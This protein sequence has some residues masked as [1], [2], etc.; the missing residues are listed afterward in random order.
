[1]EE[2]KSAIPPSLKRLIS[3]STLSTIP[4]SCSSLLQFFL[5]LPQF[6]QIVGDLVDRDRA[7]CG[8]NKDAALESKHNGNDC[9]AKADYA[10]ALRFYS[11]ALRDAPSDVDVMGRNLVSTLY[12]N[13]ATV[14]HRVGLLVECLRDCGRALVISPHYTKAWYRRGKVNASLGNYE[15]AVRDLTVAMNVESAL[16][17]KRKIES[18]LKQY[19]DRK[20]E[21]NGLLD[22][23]SEKNF[24]SAAEATHTKLEC[25]STPTKGRGMVSVADI[26]PSSLL[27]IEEPFAAVI[28]KH[29]RDTHCHFC[30]NKLPVDTVPC[31]SCT[32]PLYCSHQCQAQA[33]GQKAGSALKSRHNHISLSDDLEKYIADITS[34]GF[35]TEQNSE[36]SHECGGV[37]WPVVLPSEIILAGRILMKL[38]KQTRHSG[39]S[40]CVVKNMDLCHNYG[41]HPSDV[42]LYLHIHSIILLYCLQH[43][44]SAELQVDG[45]TL[46]QCIILLCQIKVNS[47]AIVRLNSLDG[48]ESMVPSTILSPA[49]N[50][51]TS[52]VEQVKV[53]QAIYSAG[54]LF[55]HSCQPNIHAYFISRTLYVRSTEYV[56]AGYPLELSYGPQVGQWDHKDRQRL[57]KN[58]YSFSCQCSSCSRINLPDLVLNAFRCTKPNCFG[59]V[60]DGHLLY[61]KQMVSQ[62]LDIHTTCSSNPHMQ[63]RKL[64]YEEIKR[65]A[66]C[67]FEQTDSVHQFEPGVCLTCGS[68]VNPE[69]SAETLNEATQNSKRLKDAIVFN[70]VSAD[71]LSYSLRCLDLLRSKLHAYNKKIAELEDNLAQAFCLVGELQHAKSHCKASMQIL[72]KLYGHN[73][74][75]IGNELVK[76]ASIQLSLGDSA[77][78]DTT[79]QVD[80][81]FSQ[82]YGAHANIILPQLE[83]LKRE[84]IKLTSQ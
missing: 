38:V 55:N 19:M 67:V 84:A 48:K 10:N 71:T 1:M 30:F 25:V 15:N 60:L 21:R 12:L 47:I 78:I 43:Y 13:R 75:V 33:S 51:L 54:S 22:C 20:N 35:C 29:C 58:Q 61:E 81:I 72:E 31:S 62:C 39:G 77:T 82:Y 57:L 52:T 14:L 45:A 3:E 17:E 41:D 50:S 64:E 74:I 26:P 5:Q 9:F 76:L 16:V 69:T 63:I 27:H 65:V 59:A 23:A 8:K 18:E 44:C 28:L 83:Y 80:A 49:G 56:A 79:K 2:L 68:H 40:S 11:K 37:N 24:N 6:H 4:S 66:Q 46:S 34:S 36:H 32:I 70:Q 73:H 42:K 53:G 7:L